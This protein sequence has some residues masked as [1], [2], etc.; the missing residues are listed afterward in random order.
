[1]N[2]RTIIKREREKNRST[3]TEVRE[4]SVEGNGR[5]NILFVSFSPKESFCRYLPLAQC[6]RTQNRVSSPQYSR[7]LPIS[8]QLSP[9]FLLLLQ[10][11]HS[12]LLLSSPV[13]FLVVAVIVVVVV[14]CVL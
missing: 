12:V 10:L 4:Y 5:E 13:F 3:Q 7:L 1:M 2:Q 11:L 9:T 8:V 6:R 14:V